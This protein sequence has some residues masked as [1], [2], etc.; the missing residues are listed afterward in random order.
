MNTIFVYKRQ[1]IGTGTMVHQPNKGE[2]VKW[3]NQIFEVEDVMFDC[4]PNGNVN[5]VVYLKDTTVDTQ[6]KLRYI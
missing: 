6:N 5:S 1:A 4:M 2:Y 3:L